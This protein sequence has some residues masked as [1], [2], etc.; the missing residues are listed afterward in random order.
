MIASSDTFN[1]GPRNILQVKSLLTAARIPLV[2][3][4]TGGT[5]SRTV[6]VSVDTGEVELSSPGQPNWKI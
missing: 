1:I 5:Y 6:S 3:E 4:D 2:A